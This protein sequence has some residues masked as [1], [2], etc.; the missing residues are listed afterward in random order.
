MLLFLQFRTVDIF[1]DS[2]A[3]NSFKKTPFLLS[4]CEYKS[5]V[6]DLSLSFFML[7]QI[8]SHVFSFHYSYNWLFVLL[9]SV[10]FMEVTFCGCSYELDFLKLEAVF[11]FST[12]KACA[13]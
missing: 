2:I 12:G 6:V 10:L 9:C 5:Q 13:G 4:L 1:N 3:T 8:L 11:N 7:G